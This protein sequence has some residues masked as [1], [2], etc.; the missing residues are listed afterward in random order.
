M[1]A[2][3]GLFS[4]VAVFILMFHNRSEVQGSK[5]QRFKGSGVSPA[6]SQRTAGQT[7]KETPKN[8]MTKEGILPVES[9]PS[10]TSGSNDKVV[11]LE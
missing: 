2:H 7:E 1:A 8:R 10:R 6:A 5:V 11:R 9:L 3:Q 4:A